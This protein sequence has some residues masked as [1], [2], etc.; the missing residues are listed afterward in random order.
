M[1]VRVN[2]DAES[3]LEAIDLNVRS[4]DQDEVRRIHEVLNAVAYILDEHAD[5]SKE[6]EA[7]TTAQRRALLTDV[8][9]SSIALQVA[10]SKL[11]AKSRQLSVGDIDL[12]ALKSQLNI[13]AAAAGAEV[14]RLRA[15][16]GGRP[17]LVA[18]RETIA[19]LERLFARYAPHGSDEDRKEFVGAALRAAGIEAPK[20]LRKAVKRNAAK[21]LSK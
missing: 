2:A 16:N 21:T 20:D 17:K 11:D 4:S 19:S 7:V 18:R 5:L 1:T 14:G 9:E 3:L 13:L 12:S 15:S 10:L 8:F 6:L